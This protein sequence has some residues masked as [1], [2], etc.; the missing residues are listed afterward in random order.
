MLAFVALQLLVV[1]VALAWIYPEHR[2]IALIAVRTLDAERKA[3]FDSL[4][5][6]ARTGH[7]RRLCAAGADSEQGV[8]P[9]CIDWAALTAIAGDHS[10]SSKEML[11]TVLRSDWILAVADV[12]AQLKED[13]S[14]IGA[15]GRPANVN[16]LIPDFQRYVEN[17]TVRAQ[18]VNA[19]RTSDTRLQRA[20]P[21]YATRAGSNGAHFLLPRPR[22][23]ITPREYAELTLTSGAEISAIGSYAWYHLSALQKAT[24]L[25][26]EQLAPA[27]R[28]ALAR[29]MLA[30]EA[31]ALHF[32]EDTFA[33]G[34]VAGAW[35][36][37]SQRKGTHDYY[38]EAGLEAFT[39]SGGSTSAVLLG[40]AH[41]RPQDAERAG[42]AVRT[43][44]AQ[45][46][47]HASG[48]A[49]ANSLAHT[50]GA[51]SSADDFDVCKN[52]F[53]VT[54]KEGLRGTPE[55]LQLVAEVLR[56]T[57]IPSLGPGLGSMPRFRAEVG[58]FLGFAASAGVR[59]LGGGFVD[60]QTQN[61]WMGDF[62]LSARLG[63]GL[64]GVL[65]D[66]GDGLV[67]VSL[68]LRGDS[69]SSNKISSSTRA[70]QAGSLGAAIPN[71]MGISTR[72]RMPYYLI[73][74][75]LLF[76]SPLYL[77]SPTTYTNMAVTASNG[78][79][80]PWQTGI[81]TPIGRFQFVLGRE[82]GVTFNGVLQHDSLIAPAS[83]AG[84]P[85]ILVDYKS[86][87]YDL[88]I[89]E[90][91]PWRAFDTQ[92]S[93]AAIVQL[94]VG[95]DVPHGVKVV[96]PIGAPAPPTKTVYSVGLRMLFDWRRY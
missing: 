12:A 68:G 64:E 83:V 55:A 53:L 79:L 54:R 67:F 81:A 18:L 30:D 84:G 66:A 23:D 34:H 69:A 65:G 57:P 6:E 20:D 62:D 75:D 74:G 36:E 42:A 60:S 91:R 49:R 28:Q 16:P 32:L 7:E 38:N 85:P 47:D 4:W 22:T 24:R 33:A 58:P 35:G 59:S 13:L 39:W 61:G 17:E 48:R 46:I 41:M 77:A 50:P 15:T 10:C 25:G 27:E 44:L 19:L 51:P 14:R 5:A 8:A 76:M 72:L 70:E 63:L 11:D 31:F 52:N 89:L 90:Y 93:S 1:N 37:T 78:G 73:P 21:Q 87:F 9:D 80:I 94:Y 96:S 26:N 40:D 82:L 92:Q 43:S 3:Q 29:A 45:V 88:P 56:A 86:I 71:R 2:T 95:A